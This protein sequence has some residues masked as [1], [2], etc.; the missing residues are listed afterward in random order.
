VNIQVGR[1]LRE[2]NESIAGVDNLTTAYNILKR[3]NSRG[4]DNEVVAFLESEGNGEDLEDLA[5]ELGIDVDVTVPTS[6]TSASIRQPNMDIWTGNFKEYLDEYTD[7]LKA[8]VVHCDFPYGIDHQKS[9]QGGVEKWQ[10]EMY[11]DSP[12][13]FWDLCEMFVERQDE[14]MTPQ[15]HIIFWFSMPFFHDVVN[16]FSPHFRID[17]CPLIWAKGAGVLPDPERGPR[18]SYEAALFMTR[19]DRKIV[20]PINNISTQPLG[21]NKLH[22]SMKP[23]DTIKYFL[24]MVVDKEAKVFDPTCGS[25]TALV[26]AEMLGAQQV[27]GLDLDPHHVTTARQQ[28][29][30]LRL[31]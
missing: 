2:Q 14:F 16:L 24:S 13:L 21:K 25:G 27:R 7:G 26:A 12:D 22:P 1:A 5:A 18:R 6:P 31:Q 9:A 23:L 10:G 20:R 11:D 28:L 3:A 8:N 19:G 17:P 4:L 30:K 29:A 15:A